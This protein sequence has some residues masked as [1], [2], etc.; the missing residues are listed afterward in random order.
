MSL[1]VKFKKKK[2]GWWGKNARP[3]FSL[4]HP[5]AD[6]GAFGR[7][8]QRLWKWRRTWLVGCPRIKA[9]SSI[10]RK[11]MGLDHRAV[12]G[13]IYIGKNW[14]R[15]ERGEGEEQEEE[16]K[17]DYSTYLCSQYLSFYVSRHELLRDYITFRDLGWFLH[18][19][20][21]FYVC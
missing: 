12:W 9:K 21:Q 4:F 18:F 7:S 17:A 14:G 3:S 2:S 8:K 10:S 6:C 13:G 16:R 20:L 15:G 11:G 1:E 19:F 5:S